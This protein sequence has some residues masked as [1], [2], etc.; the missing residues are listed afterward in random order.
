MRA[1]HQ[2]RSLDEALQL[3]SARPATIAAGCTDLFP[4]TEAQSLP[5]DVLD[6]SGVHALRGI[7]K[8]DA[9]WR[10][11]A[12]TTWTDLINAPLPPAFDMLKQAAGEVGS[13]QIQNAGTVVGNLCN[14]SPAADG[15]PPL[16]ALD[17]EVEVNGDRRVPLDRFITGPR[18]T[19]LQPGEI[20]T[21]LHVAHGAGT[22]QSAFGKL[23]ARRYLVISIAMVAVRLKLNRDQ[24][25]QAF[26]A[27]GACSPVAMRLTALELALKGV[28]LGDLGRV[29]HS[30][31]IGSALAPIDDVRGDAAY[32]R[33]AASELVRRTVLKAAGGGAE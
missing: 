20:V 28:P 15:V 21:A 16:L 17:A 4:A 19:A 2:P 13:V 7:S 10:I 32:R 12:L 5:G 30:I 1:Y 11:G 14:A 29:L 24:V 8:T 26:I 6:L 33:T 23:G 31:E 9:G 22:G 27:I 18:Q 3:L 25:A